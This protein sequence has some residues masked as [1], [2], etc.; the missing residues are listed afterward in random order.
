MV[1]SRCFSEVPPGAGMI[2][3]SPKSRCWSSARFRIVADVVYSV[4]R[5]F[6]MC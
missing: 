6:C 2:S 5:Y 3:G 4:I 1:P